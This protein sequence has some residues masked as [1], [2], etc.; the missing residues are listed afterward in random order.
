[1][2][3]V[4]RVDFIGKSK[5]RVLKGEKGSRVDIEFD[6]QINGSAASVFG[7]QIDLP[8]LTQRISLDEMALVMDVKTVGHRVVLEVRDETSDINGS[9]CYLG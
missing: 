6:V 3:L 5:N 2:K 4:G 7:V 9:H 1:M 8:R